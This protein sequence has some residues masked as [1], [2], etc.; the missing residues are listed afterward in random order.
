MCYVERNIWAYVEQVLIDVISSHLI[1]YKS[2]MSKVMSCYVQYC[3]PQSKDVIIVHLRTE[4]N[5][6]RF[7]K[8]F[9]CFI[10]YFKGVIALSDQVIEGEVFSWI[11]IVVLPVNTA[12]N[13]VIYT[14]LTVWQNRVSR[15]QVC[16]VFTCL[17]KVYDTSSFYIFLCVVLYYIFS[18]HTSIMGT[19]EQNK[20]NCHSFTYINS[21]SYRNWHFYSRA[22]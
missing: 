4:W 16:V 5:Q 1:Y 13:P 20:E 11:A 19:Y 21:F 9:T 7:Y 15:L 2:F 10:S 6:M 22:C 18:E 12:A 8:G 17:S 14:L 3:D